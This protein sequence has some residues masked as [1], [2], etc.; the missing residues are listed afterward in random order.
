MAQFDVY[1]N[2][3]AAS[4]RDIPYLLD[5]QA[6]LLGGLVTRVFIPLVRPEAIKGKLAS[7]L[8]PVLIVEG[9]PFIL[10]TQELAGIPL[11]S[12][13]RP[14]ANLADERQTILRAVDFVISGI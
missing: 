10:L 7:I 13:K 14:V 6:G 11:K 2:P 5:I 3:V 4:A 9:K 8:N 1:R 12:F